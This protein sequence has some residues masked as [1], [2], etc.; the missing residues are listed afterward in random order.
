MSAFYFFG[1]MASLVISM[2]LLPPLR[3]TASRFNFLD[4]PNARKVHATPI[5]KIGGLAFSAGT[6]AAIL[7]WAPKEDMVLGALLGGAVIVLFGAW[8]DRVC[9]GY[10][11]KFFG[12]ILAAACAIL[13]GHIQIH[14]VGL[15][16]DGAIPDSVCV[17]L[18]VVFIVGVTNAINLADGLDGLAGGI[19]FLSFAAIGYLAYMGGDTVLTLL[20]LSLLGGLLGFLRFNTYPARIFMGDAGSQFLGFF[21]A[22]FSLMLADPGRSGY[23]VLLVFIL[24]GLPLLDTIGVFTQRLID[25][26]SPFVA[27]NNHLH[28]RLLNM[29][30][31][32]G[33]AVTAIYGIQLVLVGLALILRWHTDVILL[34]T[35]ICAAGSII[36]LFTLDLHIRFAPYLQTVRTLALETHAAIETRRWISALPIRALATVTPPVLVCS[37]LW[38]TSIPIDFAWLSGSLVLLL[39]ITLWRQSAFHP[40]IIRLSLYVGTVST[41]YLGSLSSH[42]LT[43]LPVNLV[44]AVLAGL[45]VLTIRFGEGHRF[46]AT[47][48]DYLMGFLALIIPM[49]PELGIGVASMSLLT[50]KVIVLLFAIEL[51]LHAYARR[52]VHL[53][54]IAILIHL[55]LAIRGGL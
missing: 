11:A 30:L 15:L 7:L 35:F 17:L 8:D 43:Q 32:H 45:V 6:F 46:Q 14:T 9:L 44:L 33:E 54:I 31:S 21:L 36:G 38:P 20:V 23:S 18:T 47:P 51:L 34:L 52:I 49:L 5:A 4:V 3:A 12:Q 1:F 53:T 41:M 50:A 10:R 48:L 26:R 27:D 55:A 42:P 29:G 39:V 25:G 2:A 24:L 19:S 40:K 22:V 37:T 16:E 13:I 28:H